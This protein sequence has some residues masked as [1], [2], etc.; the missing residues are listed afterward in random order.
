MITG[1]VINANSECLFNT[2]TRTSNMFDRMKGLLGSTPLTQQQGMWLEPCNSVHT[3]FMAYD[4]DVVFLDAN[5][6][7]CKT[8]ENLRP[9]RMAGCSGA[10]TTLELAAGALQNTNIQAGQILKWQP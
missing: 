9:W 10:R 1:K 6:I 5:G 4:I 2:V 7:I 3:F 8:V